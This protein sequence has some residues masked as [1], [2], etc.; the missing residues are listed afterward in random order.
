MKEFAVTGNVLDIDALKALA[1]FYYL[2]VYSDYLLSVCFA[3]CTISELTCIREL[4]KF[5][6]SKSFQCDFNKH[7]K[8]KSVHAY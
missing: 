4:T 2:L 3:S 8:N 5:L 1:P 7:I 6:L